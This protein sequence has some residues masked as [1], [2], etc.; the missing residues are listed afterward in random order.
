M[1]RKRKENWFLM[2]VVPEFLVGAKVIVTD[3]TMDV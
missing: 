2:Y 1:P 3:Q